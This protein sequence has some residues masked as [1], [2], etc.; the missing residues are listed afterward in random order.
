MDHIRVCTGR[1]DGRKKSRI[2]ILF[3]SFVYNSM[4]IYSKNMCLWNRCV[5]LLNLQL[6]IKYKKILQTINYVWSLSLNSCC[7]FCKSFTIDFK[8]LFIFFKFSANCDRS[9][10]NYWSSFGTA[11]GIYHHTCHH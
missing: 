3:D 2:S 9:K 1:T 10:V 6:Y 4:S 5:F 11:T 7:L 8:Q